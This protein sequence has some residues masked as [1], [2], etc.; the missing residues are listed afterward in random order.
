[1]EIREWTYHLYFLFIKFRYMKIS[2]NVFCFD[3]ILLQ[4]Y[5]YVSSKGGGGAVLVVFFFLNFVCFSFWKGEVQ[6]L[7]LWKKFE[8]EID[9]PVEWTNK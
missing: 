2:K 5:M 8:N 1:M 9:K 6:K 3:S 7:K 4:M